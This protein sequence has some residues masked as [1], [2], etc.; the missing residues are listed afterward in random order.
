MRC[1]IFYR[2]WYDNSLGCGVQTDTFG[3]I[4]MYICDESADLQFIHPA[5]Q[6]HH[7]C[8]V[9]PFLFDQ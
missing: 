3:D 1:T 4:Y 6:A 5:S 8:Y 7:V 9:N 2:D